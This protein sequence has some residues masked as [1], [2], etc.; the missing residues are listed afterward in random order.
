VRRVTGLH[1]A[2]ARLEHR[3]QAEGRESKSHGREQELPERLLQDRLQGAVQPGLLL[4]E[5]QR[6]V[7]EQAPNRAQGYPVGLKKVGRRRMKV[8]PRAGIR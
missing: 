8:R 2:V 1:P 4:V 6:R 5:G 7:A 3:E